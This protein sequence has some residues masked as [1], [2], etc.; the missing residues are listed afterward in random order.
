MALVERFEKSGRARQRLHDPVECGY[1]VFDVGQRRILQLDTYGSN[2][3]VMPGKVSQS[4]QIDEAG[5]VALL[6]VIR[7]AFPSLQA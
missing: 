7:Q 4:F 6:R 5:A 3:R 1:S 2:Y